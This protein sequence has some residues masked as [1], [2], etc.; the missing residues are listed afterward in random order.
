MKTKAQA[1]K[2]GKKLLKRLKGKGWKLRVWENIG[3]HYS[4]RN[5]PI[6]VY[7]SHT[8]GMYSCLLS[9]RLDDPIGGSALWTTEFR[10]KDPNKVVAHEV[11]AARKQLNEIIDAVSFVERIV[12]N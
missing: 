12:E 8:E 4:A 7:E 5:G 9:D 2:A 11:K 10:N 1:E 3:W 6:N